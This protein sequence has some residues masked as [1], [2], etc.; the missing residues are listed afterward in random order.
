MRIR[1][2]TDL[3][4]LPLALLMTCTGATLICAA[5]TSTASGGTLGCSRS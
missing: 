3:A 5:E 1:R 4:A 2:L